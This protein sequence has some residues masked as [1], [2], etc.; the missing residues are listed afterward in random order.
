[1]NHF[2][3][4]TISA[5]QLLRW[6]VLFQ[7]KAPIANLSAMSLPLQV[8]RS[9][10]ELSV[11]RFYCSTASTDTPAKATAHSF[12]PKK[13]PVLLTEATRKFFKSLLKTKEADTNVIGIMLNYHQSSSGE[14]RMVF[15]FDFVRADQLDKNDER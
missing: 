3:K 15:S 9:K 4:S 13:A 7:V 5:K 14:P 6:A 1:M 10:N 11:C 2:A 12:I 8:L